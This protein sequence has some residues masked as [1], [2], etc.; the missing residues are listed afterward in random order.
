MKKIYDL[1]E[2]LKPIFENKNNIECEIIATNE[3]EKYRWDTL[4]TKEPETIEWIRN[5][6][7]S[8]KLLDIGAN[9]GVYSFTAIIKGI[10][11]VIAIE[12]YQKNYL[13][14]CR[15]I[16]KNNIDNIFPLNFAIGKASKLLN[17]KNKPT[18]IGKKSKISQDS[19]YCISGLAEFEQNEFKNIDNSTVVMLDIDKIE[20]FPFNEIT[21]L[22]IDVDGPECDVI[23]SCK[24]ILLSKSIKS[25]LIEVTI[26]KTDISINDKL[27]S[28]GFVKDKYYDQLEIHSKYRR[29]NDPSNKAANFVYK[30]I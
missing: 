6:D 17:F 27:L 23:N 24:S 7:K 26:G 14:L 30:K 13:S 21:H 9:I 11:S 10:H 4:L 29:R 5:M 15:N 25:I 28:M 18:T 22:K 12:P 19:N 16:E 2:I 20:S 8:S 3:I 1:N